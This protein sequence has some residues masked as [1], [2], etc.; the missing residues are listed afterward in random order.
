MLLLDYWD[1]KLLDYFLLGFD[2]VDEWK[3]TMA[4]AARNIAGN[5]DLLGIVQNFVNS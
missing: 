3:V 2:E 5:A 4:E 1:S